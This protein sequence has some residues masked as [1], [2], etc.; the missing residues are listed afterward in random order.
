MRRTAAP[1]LDQVF[2]ALSDPTRRRILERLGSREAM[3]SELAAPHDMSLAAVSKHI[4]VLES[5]GLITRRVAGRQHF[6]RLK[7]DPFHQARRWLDRQA[8]FWQGS[9]DR[10]AAQLESAASKSKSPPKSRQP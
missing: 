7:P 6:L 2:A 10:L 4:R 9:L 8:Q 1:S 3:V 5:A